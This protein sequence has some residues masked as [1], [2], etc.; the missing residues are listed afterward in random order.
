M[1]WEDLETKLKAKNVNENH[2]KILR[3]FYR[4]AP[5]ENLSK[6]QPKELSSH[7]KR[8]WVRSTWLLN[9]LE[10]DLM[11]GTWTGGDCRL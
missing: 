7:T 8:E 10:K 5:P 4:N 6:Q 1:M 9:V 2:I 3:R 11:K